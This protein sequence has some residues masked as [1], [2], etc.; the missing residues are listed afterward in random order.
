MKAKIKFYIN[1]WLSVLEENHNIRNI[2]FVIGFFMYSHYENR[3]A[4]EE[5]KL[6]QEDSLAQ[7]QV[8]SHVV[9]VLELDARCKSLEQENQVLRNE[10]EKLTNI[11]KSNQANYKN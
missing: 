4:L 3:L 1:T 5:M 10:N 2:I 7:I 6:L 9:K 11:L 8:L